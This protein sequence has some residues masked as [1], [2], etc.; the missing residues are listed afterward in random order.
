MI[1]NH[2]QSDLRKKPV[3]A[4]FVEQFKTYFENV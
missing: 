3:I 2:E 1:E 4:L